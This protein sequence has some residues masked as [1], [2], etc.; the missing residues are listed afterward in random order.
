MVP[1]CSIMFG[2]K[3]NKKLAHSHFN[4]SC[5]YPKGFIPNPDPSLK[6]GTSIKNPKI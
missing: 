6:T 1:V 4:K 2:P 5:V 3:N